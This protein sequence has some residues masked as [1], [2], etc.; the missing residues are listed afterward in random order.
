MINCRSEGHALT[1]R[2]RITMITHMKVVHMR[3]ELKVV[4]NL[5]IHTAPQDLVSKTEGP[6]VLTETTASKIGRGHT[7]IMTRTREETTTGEDIIVSIR[8]SLGFGM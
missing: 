5:Q 4:R 8:L 3:V 2:D 7:E 1:S 6:D